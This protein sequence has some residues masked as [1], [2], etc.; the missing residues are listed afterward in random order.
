LRTS[1]FGPTTEPDRGT[2]TG[3]PAWAVTD[4]PT[5]V[6]PGMVRVTDAVLFVGLP[7]A[8]KPF[9]SILPSIVTGPT[10]PG[11]TIT[12]WSVRCEE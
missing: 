1:T 10:R 12:H 7:S 5:A 4:V 11:G 8:K 3:V 6:A 2:V 9:G